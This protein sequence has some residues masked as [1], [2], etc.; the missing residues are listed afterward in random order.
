MSFKEEC[1]KVYDDNSKRYDAEEVKRN[2]ETMIK[3][4]TQII[5]EFERNFGM[6]FNEE[7]LKQEKTEYK[8]IFFIVMGDI[9]LLVN[10]S[11]WYYPRYH[12]MVNCNKCGKETTYRHHLNHSFKHDI[13]RI[14]NE[15]PKSSY[16]SRTCRDCKEE[17][18][19]KK[20]EI[21]EANYTKQAK[22]RNSDL[23]TKLADVLAEVF[24]RG[25]YRDMIS[26]EEIE[27]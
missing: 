3:E 1:L 10:F 5:K 16:Y 2:N 4:R 23:Y 7:Y 27:G 13:G 24:R 6:P 12:L 11:D 14:L 18:R 25:G 19:E 9:K 8:T 26:D 22:E 15:D 21:R 20:R 17:E